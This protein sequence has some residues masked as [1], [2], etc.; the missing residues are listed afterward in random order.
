MSGNFNEELF[1]KSYSFLEEVKQQEMKQ[2]RT[3]V[4]KTADIEEKGRIKKALEIMVSWIDNL[5][6]LSQESREQTQKKKEEAQKLKRELRRKEAER[7]AA[8]KKPFYI[9]RT[10]VK[11][12]NLKRK[13]QEL[14]DKGQLESFMKQQRKKVAAKQHRLMPKWFNSIYSAY[15]VVSDDSTSWASHYSTFLLY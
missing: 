2:L 1:K 4:K 3:A 8:G 5:C 14:K 9:G 6:D 7:V 15:I 10:A 13:Y 11:E 12:E